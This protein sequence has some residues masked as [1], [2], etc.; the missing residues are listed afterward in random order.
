MRTSDA[1]R[2]RIVEKALLLVSTGLLTVCIF[3][4]KELW[5]YSQ[6]TRDMVIDHRVDG[7]PPVVVQMIDNLTSRM[8]SEHAAFLRA[9]EQVHERLARMEEQEG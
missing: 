1:E 4:L 8:D 2:V 3:V 5:A 9:L 7:H 6:E